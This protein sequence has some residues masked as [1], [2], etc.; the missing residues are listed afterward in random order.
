MT[1]VTRSVRPAIFLFPL[2]LACQAD[3]TYEGIAVGNPGRMR[4][5]TSRATDVAMTSARAESAT[6]TF[7]DCTG[8]EQVLASAVGLDLLGGSQL[9]APAGDWCE[10][11]VSFDQPIAFAG[12]RDDATFALDLDLP[13]LAVAGNAFAATDRSLVL[14]VGSGDWLGDELLELEPG[15]H[16]E[17]DD[18]DDR[19]DALAEIAEFA[20]VLAEDT[21]DD[22]D[23]DEHE[24]V[25]AG[26]D[27]LDWD[28]DDED[29]EDDSDDEPTGGC[30]GRNALL[31]LPLL[32]P[33]LAR[34]RFSRRTLQR[35]GGQTNNNQKG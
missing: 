8:T 3:T 7:I 23:L 17:I 21:D 24:T 1:A 20:S 6:V 26:G 32:T 18:T 13:E 33:G 14:Q 2:L 28:E 30:R 27:D 5:S 9:L 25:L 16:T 11:F 19:H 31:L 4:V 22:G 29:E 34:R 10:V 12:S 35:D 15:E